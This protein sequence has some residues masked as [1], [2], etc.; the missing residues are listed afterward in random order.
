M[1]QAIE[2][3]RY[4]EAYGQAGTTPIPGYTDIDDVSYKL[5][6]SSSVLYLNSINAAQFE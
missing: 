1:Q 2:Y 3:G 6:V 5:K 4:E